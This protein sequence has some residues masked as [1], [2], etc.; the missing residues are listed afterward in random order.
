MIRPDRIT[1]AISSV[2]CVPVGDIM[3]RRRTKNVSLARQLAMYYTYKV[4]NTVVA[5]GE[6]FDRHYTNVVH[7]VK[8]VTNWKEC[9]WEI[10]EIAT[11]VEEAIPE[12]KRHNNIDYQI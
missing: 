1:Q 12:L 5:V 9:D 3:S 6:I 4:G 2:M 7:A 11:K 8:N 10:Q